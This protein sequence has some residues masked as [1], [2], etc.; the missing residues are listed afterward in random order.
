MVAM[1]LII[2]DSLSIS[3]LLNSQWILLI[4]NVNILEHA[5]AGGYII[6]TVLCWWHLSAWHGRLRG[7]LIVPI[8][9]LLFSYCFVIVIFFCWFQPIHLCTERSATIFVLGY[10]AR[11]CN[12]SSKQISTPKTV[13]PHCIRKGSVS[14]FFL[15]Y[16]LTYLGKFHF[17][18]NIFRKL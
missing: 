18:K 8:T 12:A 14:N 6:T 15:K 7:S 13:Y 11:F 4:T 9:R 3:P 5:C 17:K 1:L 2:M 10:N 16:L